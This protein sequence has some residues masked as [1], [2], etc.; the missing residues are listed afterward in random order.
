MVT[1]RTGY[2]LSAGKEELAL[3][4][5]EAFFEQVIGVRVERITDAQENYELGD[6]RAPSGVTIECKGQPI[7]PSKYN[8]L[9]FVEIFEVTENERHRGGLAIVAELLGFDLIDVERIPVRMN[10]RGTP[11][12]LGRPD[13]VSVSIKSMTTSGWTIYVNSKGGHVYLYERDEMMDL[14]K[15]AVPTGLARGAGMSNEDTFAVFIPLAD[16]RWSRDPQGL[17]NWTG[18]GD[19][20]QA[21]TSVRESLGLQP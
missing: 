21:V 8:Q 19:E 1:R 12:L 13:F 11:R 20:A 5:A 6:F 14:L 18:S 10:G 2:R 3:V 4:A 9:N 17:W 15:A 7:N 16:R